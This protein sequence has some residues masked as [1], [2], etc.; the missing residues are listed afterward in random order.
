MMRSAEN[1]FF[2][3]CG[4][5]RKP[6]FAEMM[7]NIASFGAA[8]GTLDPRRQDQLQQWASITDRE[9]ILNDT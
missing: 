4:R 1:F 8:H 9:E 3:S 5:L 6:P 7:A 2:G